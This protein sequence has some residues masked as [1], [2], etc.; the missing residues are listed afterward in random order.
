L[1]FLL[2]LSIWEFLP[3]NPN[4]KTSVY[5]N[6]QSV[7][8]ADIAINGSFSP[9]AVADTGTPALTDTSLPPTDTPTPIGTPLPPTATPT[10]PT[11]TPLPPTA[12]PKPTVTPLPPTATP[13]STFTPK[14]TNTNTLLPPTA[15]A[16]NTQTSIP[17]TPAPTV[18]PTRTMAP[19]ITATS[20]AT[21][22]LLP[23]TATLAITT[24]LA[25]G[26]D[27]AIALA[28]VSAPTRPG[29]TL[30]YHLT[31]LNNGPL[32]A[33]NVIITAS[34][35]DQ[36]VY[37]GSSCINVIESGNQFI[38]HLDRLSV[39][40]T[41][42]F[43]I[44]VSINQQAAGNITFITNI[45]SNTQDP[46]TANNSVRL[47]TPIDSEKP[48]VSWVSPTVDGK[49]LYLDNS[50]V[51][52]SVTATDNYGIARVRIYR[53]DKVGLRFIDII[54]LSK[55]PYELNLDSTS[56]YN[57]WNEIDA[58]AYDTAGNVS[59]HQFIFL[60]QKAFIYLPLVK[61]R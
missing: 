13:T 2:G 42:Q 36:V 17:P 21:E 28:D 27:L 9:M 6:I 51:H 40:T 8:A 58:E 34:L 41:N 5:Q 59:D 11:D 22:T 54:N 3:F 39:R 50:L 46:L 47:D 43:D 25:P 44:Q 24:T 52:L 53:W 32:D 45:S 16:A 35:S 12:T 55:S 4:G 61:F 60:F 31:V 57:G 56:L 10:T 18:T 15:T 26:G 20:I 30:T 37:S 33:I 29:N 23:P 1:W 14:P 19:T 48:T 38:C 49:G 7:L